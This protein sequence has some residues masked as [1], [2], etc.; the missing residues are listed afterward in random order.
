MK[1]FNKIFG[2]SNQAATIEPTIAKAIYQRGFDAA[3]Y[4]RFRS[5]WETQRNEI[6]REIQSDRPALN[7]RAYGL[8]INNPM[9]AAMDYEDRYFVIGPEGF[10]LQPS[11]EY[12]DGRKDDF[13]NKLIKKEFDKWCHKKYCNV[14]RRWSFIMMQYL[15]KSHLRYDGEVI[16]RQYYKG[17]AIK[18]NPYGYTLDFIDPNDIDFNKNAQISENHFVIM[19]VHVDKFRRILG[20]TLKDKNP[21]QELTT[22]YNTFS[23]TTFIPEEEI[24]FGFDP[25]HFKQIHGITNLAAVMLILKDDDMWQNYT[26]Q[27]AKY[28]SAKF[29]VLETSE[30]D[31]QPYTGSPQLDANGNPILGTEQVAADGFGKYM[32]IEE[33]GFIEETPFGKKMNVFDP[34]F[35]T[36]QHGPFTKTNGRRIMAGVGKDY[37]VVTGDREQES[38]SAAKTGEL[39][40]KGS[41]EYDQTIMRE[42][43]L[44]AIY[45]NW[46]KYA[47][48]KGALSPLE[49]G[50]YEKYTQHYWQGYRKQWVDPRAKVESDR[51]E[52]IYGYK[53]K[54]QNITERGNRMNE[55]FDDKAEYERYKEK[56]K[57]DLEIQ[58]NKPVVIEKPKADKEEN[59]NSKT[60]RTADNIIRIA[61]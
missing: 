38:F 43:W 5:N 21:Y 28:S 40:M 52:E 34:K 53:S 10:D 58:E 3:R 7:A 15:I 13:A 27:N 1:I 25:L 12:P 41:Y 26:L 54:K 42:Q 8:R 2:R 49:Y 31:A 59:D 30:R 47:L 48:R 6:N 22:G 56:Y 50:L 61:N 29:A 19:G 35:P 4:S 24:I 46:L 37:S 18:D 17:D 36:D 16:L 9:V 20:I 44:I 33:G 45:E 60:Q 57:I 14:S 32:D 55:M 39:K 23:N 51:L 11:S